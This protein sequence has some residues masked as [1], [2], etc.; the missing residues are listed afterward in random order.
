MAANPRISVCIPAYNRASVLPQLLDSICAQDYG[1][2]EIVICEDCSPQRSEI[3][4]IAADYAS[5]Y[6]GSIRY[7]ENERNL[8]YDGNLRR[9]VA[10]AAGAYC[11]F[12]GNDDLLC[13][14]A[15]SAIAAAIA[16]HPDIG[17]VLRSY[18]AFDGDP[19]HIVQEFRY[20]D[21]E[22]FFPPGADSIGTVFRR[23]VVISGMVVH[24]AAAAAVATDRFDGILLYQLYLVARILVH[25]GCVYL[26]QILALYRNGGIPDFGNAEAERGKFVPREHTPE[27][28]LHFMR[29]M[30][31]I[32]RYVEAADGVAICERIVRDLGNYSYPI[33]AIQHDKPLGVFWRYYRTLGGLGFDRA[34]LFHAYF[35]ALVVLGPRAIERIVKFIKTKLGYT[36]AI[37]DIYRGRSA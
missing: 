12:M 37:G 17:V 16:R 14:G 10:C 2:F 22:L 3:A 6:P 35:L 13:P 19:S 4:R 9:L 5:R 27:S 36:P 26:P 33:L 20:F 1:D 31:E 18:A 8:G 25:H 15:L 30:L 34:L 7:V 21:R 23:S 24:R 28:S 29:G 11:V 32:A